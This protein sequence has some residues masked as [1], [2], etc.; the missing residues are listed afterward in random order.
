[1]FRI[2][3]WALLFIVQLA[4]S[5]PAEAARQGLLLMFVEGAQTLHQGQVETSPWPVRGYTLMN[6]ETK[7]VTTNF[8]P[9]HLWM[10]ELDEGI[11][12]LYSVRFA[13]NLQID[14]CGE[15]YFRVIAGRVNNA[16]H[17][18]FGAS[19]AEGTSG[20]IYSLHDLDKTLAEARRANSDTFRKYS[21]GD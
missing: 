16:G 3:L 15:P 17:W 4:C 18:R 19:V 10:V 12:C 8:S 6:I 20:L 2:G 14:Y 5:L 11:Y 9:Y 7:K 1:M 21:Q 13:D